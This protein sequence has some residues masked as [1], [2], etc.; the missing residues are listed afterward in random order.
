VWL[1]DLDIRRVFAIHKLRLM[2]WAISFGKLK[3]ANVCGI[4]GFLLVFSNL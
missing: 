2:K 3:V 1:C 4:A